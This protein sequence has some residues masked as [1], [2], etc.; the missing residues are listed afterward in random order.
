VN[1]LALALVL[2]CTKRVDTAAELHQA[3]VAHEGEHAEQHQVTTETAHQ[4]VT[5]APMHEV[6]ETVVTIPAK[7][8]GAQPRTLRR[9][10]T[11]DRGPKVVE[12]VSDRHIEAAAIETASAQAVATVDTKATSHTEVTV[13]PPW[14]LWP[15]VVVL[16]LAAIAGAAAL[17]W[18]VPWH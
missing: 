10:R 3:T 9:V 8:P 7:E 14:W 17:K 5:E 4:V 2:A 1:R 11:I 18:G 6:I 13:G 16:V 15:V 12:S